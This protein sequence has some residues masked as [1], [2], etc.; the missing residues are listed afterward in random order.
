[1]S[2]LL[3]AKYEYTI[4]GS[5]DESVQYRLLKPQSVAYT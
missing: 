2:D 5:I 4:L 3:K 1:M